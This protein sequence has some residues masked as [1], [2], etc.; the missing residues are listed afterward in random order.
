[1]YIR[2]LLKTYSVKNFTSVLVISILFTLPALLNNPYA[3]LVLTSTLIWSIFAMSYNIIFGQTGIINFGHTA[4]FGLAAF[5]A[6]FLMSIGVPFILALIPAILVGSLISLAMG[7]PL[8][9]V[10][11]IFY[12]IL[13]LAVAEA[14]RLS[15][16]NLARY[17][18]ASISVL[19]GYPEIAR[20]EFFYYLSVFISIIM[21]A[22]VLYGF[23]E[24]LRNLR[25]IYIGDAIFIVTVAIVSVLLIKSVVDLI[26]GDIIKGY[27]ILTVNFYYL[28]LIIFLLCYY[29]SSRLFRSPLGSVLR[30]IRENPSR[31]EVLGYDVHIYRLYALAIGGGLAGVAG[32][33]FASEIT[34]VNATTA[35]NSMNTFLVLLAV[36]LGGAGTLLGPII[37]MIIVQFLRYF[38]ASTPVL[39]YFSMAIVGIA[40]I[41]IVL[42]FPYGIIGTWYIK[43]VPLRRRIAR[44]LSRKIIS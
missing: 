11:G 35:L 16:E 41:V 32:A 22:L 34:M 21:I 14:I 7:L 40:Y 25:G 1:M 13:T 2:A 20:S 8:R 39:M 9:R 27:Q 23:I 33:L 4:S 38:L 3:I 18:G 24:K 42:T 29:F 19:V 31:T 10:S 17:T 15:I 43:L 6:G 37:G 26:L 36:I 44:I 12:A 28:V 5:T 30:A